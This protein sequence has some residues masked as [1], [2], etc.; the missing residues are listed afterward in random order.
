MICWRLRG[1]VESTTVIFYGNPDG[2]V[3]L[4]TNRDRDSGSAGMLEDI[5]QGFLRDP[6]KFGSNTGL[7]WHSFP[8]DREGH[9][10]RRLDSH[11][12]D[13]LFDILGQR[14]IG[15]ASRPKRCHRLSCLGQTGTS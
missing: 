7:Q 1:R 11:S 2:I 10:G 6:E 3:V 8:V 12:A 4:K 15:R 13:Q 5:V 14:V 9:V